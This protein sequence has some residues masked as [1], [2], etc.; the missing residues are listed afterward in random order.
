MARYQPTAGFE[1]FTGAIS[2]KKGQAHMLVTRRKGVKDPLTGE[3]VGHGPKE[4]Y[5]QTPRDYKYHPLTASEVHQR[6]KWQ[7]ACRAASVIVHDKSHPRYMEMYER[8][9]EQLTVKEL[10]MQ[11]PNFVRAELVKELQ[12]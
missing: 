10:C 5:A 9:R 12:E 4:I 3:V 1:S 8:W 6:S 7:E 2:K 11:F